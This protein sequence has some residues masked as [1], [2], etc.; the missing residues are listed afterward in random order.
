MSS[1]FKRAHLRSPLQTNVLYECDDNVF[2]ANSINISEG[3]VLIEN[4]PLVPE[5]N[6]IPL[7]L[8][9]PQYPDLHSQSASFLKQVKLEE[10]DQEILRMRARMVRSFD[11]QSAVDKI[12]VH[13]VGCEFVGPHPRS[14]KFIS[15][16]VSSFARNVIYLLG[17]FESSGRR[18]DQVDILRNVARLLGYKHDEKLSLLRQNVLHDY[19]SLESL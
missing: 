4:L 1:R 2:K 10:L 12:F 7:M 13:Q 15:D 18:A 8:C 19:Q 14:Q 11:G 9:L 5:I 16:Y 3:G 17:L 6:S